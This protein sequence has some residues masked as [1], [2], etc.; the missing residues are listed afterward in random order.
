MTEEQAEEKILSMVRTIERRWY[1]GTGRVRRSTSHK[2]LAM[3]CRVRGMWR[4]GKDGT[5]EV[6]NAVGYGWNVFGT[7]RW[8]KPLVKELKRKGII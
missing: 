6:I 3:M 4:E 2:Y 5:Q 1:D 7:D 8:L